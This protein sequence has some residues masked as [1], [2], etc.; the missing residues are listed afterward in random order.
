VR[1][2][3]AG[4]GFL[5]AVLARRLAG[6]GHDAVV[7]ETRDHVPGSC[8]TERVAAT[9]VLVRRPGPHL[10]HSG[11]EGASDHVILFGTILDA[12]RSGATRRPLFDEA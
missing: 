3:T 10:F 6:A 7:L 11:D 1:V 8:P 9:Q 4:A 2:G 5:G 12:V